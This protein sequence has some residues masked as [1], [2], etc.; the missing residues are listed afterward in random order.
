MRKHPLITEPAILFCV[1]RS[2]HPNAFSLPSAAAAANLHLYDSTRGVWK[3]NC[4]RL[5]TELLAFA[6]F[7]HQIVAVYQIQQWHHAGTT[8]YLSG[9]SIAPA[10]L[11]SRVEFTGIPEVEIQNKYIRKQVPHLGRE[12][13][14]FNF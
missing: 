8:P 13:R 5:P 11:S 4:W 7:Q 2:Y 9:R 1:D 12:F 14:F 10:L 3:L 6:V